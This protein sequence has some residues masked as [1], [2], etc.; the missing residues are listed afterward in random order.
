[1]K[2]LLLTLLFAA[3]VLHAELQL[4]PKPT[5]TPVPIPFFTQTEP[6]PE[7]ATA[8]EFLETSP[9][10]EPLPQEVSL[11]MMLFQRP[12]TDPVWPSSHPQAYERVEELSGWGAQGQYVTL[13]FAVYPLADLKNLT[14]QVEDSSIRPEVRL[15]RYW[16]VIYPFYN[17]YRD[18]TGPKRYRRMPEFLMPA[19]SCDAPKNEPQRFYLTFHLPEDG[20][21]EISGNVLIYHDGMD[22]AAKMPFHIQVLP[23]QLKQDPAKHYSAYYYHVRHKDKTEFFEKNQADKEL[24]RKAQVAEFRRMKEYGFT[25]TPTFYMSFGQLPDGTKDAFYIPG[26]DEALED[27][28]SA[29]FDLTQPIPVVGSSYMMLYQKFTG[30]KLASFHM[31]NIDCSKIPQE[32]YDCMDSALEKFLAY[33]KEHDYPPMIFNPIDEPSPEALPY[34]LGIYRIFK[35]HG[36]KTFMT[37]PPDELIRQGDELF[38]IYS[39]GKFLVPYEKAVSGDKMEYWCYPNDI[40][41]QKKDPVAMC[42]GGRL[43]YGLGYWRRGFHC[44]MPWIWSVRTSDRLCNAGGN[45]MN[46]DTGE[47]YMTTY[48]ECFRLG[49]DDLRYIYTLEDA[50]VRRENST[51]PTLQADIQSA[52]ALLQNI[53]DHTCPQVIHM[54]DNLMPHAEIDA[55]RAQVAA[56]ILKLKA[57]PE[58]QD[59]TAPSVIIEPR[60]DYAW[61]KDLPDSPNVLFH[62]LHRWEPVAKEL[63][64]KEL[65]DHLDVQI[66]IDHTLAGEGNYLCGWPRVRHAF[67][68]EEKDLTRFSAIEFDL[69]VSSDRDAQ[70]DYDWPINISF[71]TAN[72]QEMEFRIANTLEPQV[73]HHF[74]IPIA[75]LTAFSQDDLKKMGFMQIFINEISYIH[76][77]H[78]SIQIDNPRMVGFRSPTILKTD[79]P[80]CVSLPL[81]NF[82]LS[83]LAGGVTEG[84]PCL[85]K[86]ELMNPQGEVLQISEM[87]VRQ[88]C[89][90]CGF[91]TTELAPGQYTIRIRLLGQDG[92]V[93]DEM[94][95]PLAILSALA[96]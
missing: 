70:T 84:T 49:V 56:M 93:Q 15:V 81:A 48:W 47:L 88:G 34:V 44:V 82:S 32:L 67:N 63:T 42:H 36:L 21:R 52:R 9:M 23:F 5:D 76:G 77:C 64:L 85:A 57:Y 46:P 62:P 78:L 29:G 87:P 69:T 35:K 26:F 43:T 40:A 95:R 14:V 89:A 74:N 94:S 39:Y 66:A 37:S 45:L 51:D 2:P 58:T 18:P 11:Q 90:T 83:V 38:D 20:A 50:V 65:P 55:I 6:I 79:A 68:A 71:K 41:F 72:G 28:K 59:V 96:E 17:S 73:K 16:N 86:A 91:Q 75:K 19:T 33:A 7:G 30:L 1:M 53:W 31:Q 80:E 92:E 3:A 54:R 22:E 8:D 24:V 13:N 61:P 25:R 12:L 60:G 10:A 27:L 4:I